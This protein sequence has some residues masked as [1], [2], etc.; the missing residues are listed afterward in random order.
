MGRCWFTWYDVSGSDPFPSYADLFYLSAYPLL[1]G[2]FVLLVHRSVPNGDRASLIDASIVAG[3]ASALAWVLLGAPYVHE[4][5][6]AIEIAVSLAYPLGDLL[7][8]GFVCR[9]LLAPALRS[10]SV[11]LLAAGTVA[12]LVAALGSSYW[13]STAPTRPA[14]PSMEVGFCFTG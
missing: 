5:G 14:I 1:A 4:G 2:G 9:L 12:M 8:L 11:H 10:P 7:V 6:S 3:G 13:T